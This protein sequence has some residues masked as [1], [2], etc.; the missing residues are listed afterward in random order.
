MVL[1]RGVMRS[2]L[3]FGT[4]PLAAVWTLDWRRRDGGGRQSRQKLAREMM[5]V[6]ARRKISPDSW[7]PT[8]GVD[9]GS[10]AV[11]VTVGRGMKSQPWAS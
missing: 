11:R 5:R 6:G 7:L 10:R 3:H 2:Y 4:M 1:S 8:A 9:V